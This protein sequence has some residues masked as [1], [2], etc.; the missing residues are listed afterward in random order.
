MNLN[1]LYGSKQ[2]KTFYYEYN[3]NLSQKSNLQS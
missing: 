2:I 3:K 1:S